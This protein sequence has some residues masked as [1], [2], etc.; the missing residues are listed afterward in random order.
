MAVYNHK[1]KVLFLAEPHCASR[2]IEAELLKSKV[3]TSVGQHQTLE[4]LKNS[5]PWMEVKATFS[6]I[7]HPCDWLVTRYSHMTGWH[8]AG[9]LAFLQNFVMLNDTC[10][11]HART[12][13]FVLRLE[14]L[15]QGLNN[16]LDIFGEPHVQLERIGKTLWKGPWQDYFWPEHLEVVQL[17]HDFEDFRYPLGKTCDPVS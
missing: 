4:Q 9:F 17:L 16:L 15:P 14:N 13:D 7:R 6:V 11:T 5:H 8:K 2:S 3:V 10:F 12:A 1:T